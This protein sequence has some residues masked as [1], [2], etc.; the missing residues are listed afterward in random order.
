MKHE[1]SEIRMGAWGRGRK[2]EGTL[3]MESGG[4][5]KRILEERSRRRMRNRE[6][7][8]GPLW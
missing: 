5:S 8:G 1:A 6:D 3:G 4:R 2:Q 7:V